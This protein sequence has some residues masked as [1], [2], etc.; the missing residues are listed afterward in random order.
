MEDFTIIIQLILLIRSQSRTKIEK[1]IV[2]GKGVM[3][4][5]AII[6]LVRNEPAN[7][8]FGAILLTEGHNPGRFRKKN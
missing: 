1:N 8:C 6:L 5:P 7:E 3:S 4:I 2:A